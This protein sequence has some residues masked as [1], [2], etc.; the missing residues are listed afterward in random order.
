MLPILIGVTPFALVAGAA[1]VQNGLSVLE[2]VGFSM[3]AFAGAAQISAAQLIGADAPIAVVIITAV[4]INLRF[5]LY[6]ADLSRLL[7]D[8]PLGSRLI[9]AY[10]ITDHAYALTE[11]RGRAGGVQLG[12]FYMGAAVTFWLTWQICNVVGAG[13]GARL[14]ADSVLT[15]AVP[16][17]FL[18]LLVPA[19]NS[20]GRGV[21][22]VVAAIVAVAAHDAPAG[23]GVL[24]AIVAGLIAGS[25][26]RRV[27]RGGVADVDA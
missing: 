18:G 17:S 3:F 25:V 23:S 1:G 20:S 15:F 2:T 8:A 5:L 16:L 6:S 21:A 9:S 14:P 26:F 13:I 27:S 4:V 22:C 19:L 7:P 10:V 24:L 11:R 12:T